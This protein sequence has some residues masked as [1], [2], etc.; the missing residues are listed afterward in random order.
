MCGYVGSIAAKGTFS[1]D[2]VESAMRT[3]AH[4]GPDA[5]GT[6]AVELGE[7]EVSISHQRLEIIDLSTKATQP[8]SS[9]PSFHLA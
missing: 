5:E 1:I 8:M 2:Q 9:G 7:A 4:R 6:L 3:I